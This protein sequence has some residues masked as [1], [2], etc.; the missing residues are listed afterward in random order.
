MFGSIE[1]IGVLR[2]KNTDRFTMVK[3][4][5]EEPI[6][7]PKTPLYPP[8]EILEKAHNPLGPIGIYKIPPIAF[9][10]PQIHLR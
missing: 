9:A 6:P 4:D 7:V 3:Q 2:A 5:R 8:V 10:K 1:A